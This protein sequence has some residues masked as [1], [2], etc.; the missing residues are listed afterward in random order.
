M[1]ADAVKAKTEAERATQEIFILAME[2]AEEY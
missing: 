1:A 2:C